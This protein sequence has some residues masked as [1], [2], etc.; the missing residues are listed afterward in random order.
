MLIRSPWLMV[1]FS[2]SPSLLIFYSMVVLSVA[3]RGVKFSVTAVD[4]SISPFSSIRFCIMYFEALSFDA[5]TFRN[6]VFSCR[7]ALLASHNAFFITG[8]FL[9]SNVYFAPMSNV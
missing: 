3:E 7:L 8:N 2:S 9:C 6:T 5:Q 1:L 4:S